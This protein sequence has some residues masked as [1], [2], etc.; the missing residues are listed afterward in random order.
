M[1]TFSI[2][3]QEERWKDKRQRQV[4]SWGDKISYP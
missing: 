3:G 1:Y 2:A 4:L